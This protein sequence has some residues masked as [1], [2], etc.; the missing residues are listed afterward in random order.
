[1]TSKPRSI[2]FGGWRL[3]E[4]RA[5]S[6]FSAASLPVSNRLVMIDDRDAVGSVA[7]YYPEMNAVIALDHYDRK[8]GTPSY[9]GVPVAITKSDAQAA[10]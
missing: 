4:L 2:W 1:M 3:V 10:A 5:D 9:K 7:G 8:S 6:T